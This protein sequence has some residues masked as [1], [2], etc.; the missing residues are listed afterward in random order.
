M[1]KPR[2]PKR[3]PR[4]KRAPDP[5]RNLHLPRGEQVTIDQVRAHRLVGCTKCSST[6]LEG[7]RRRSTTPC[8]CATRR[9]LKANPR[10]IMD[11]AGS[12]WWPAV[13][14]LT[15]ELPEVPPNPASSQSS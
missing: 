12:A 5:S 13:D 9:F 4:K 8:V 10:I 3:P 1:A 15:Q 6:G 11:R 7:D 2:K 14:P